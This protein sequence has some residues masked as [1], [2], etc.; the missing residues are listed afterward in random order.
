MPFAEHITPILR[1][2]METLRD[3]GRPLKPTEVREAVAEQVTIDPEHEERNK[4]GQIRWHAQLS[5]RTG[6]AVKIG[7]MSKENGWGITE[8]GIQALENFP[9]EGLYR[10]LSRQYRVWRKTHGTKT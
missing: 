5:F 3:A 2:A 7:W 10:E 4:D 6:E 9:G 8:L 1:A